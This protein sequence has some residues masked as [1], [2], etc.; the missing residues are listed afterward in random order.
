MRTSKETLLSVAA[1]EVMFFSDLKDLTKFC[2]SA[3]RECEKEQAWKLAYILSLTMIC[4]AFA[5]ALYP[6]ARVR[7]M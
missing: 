2:F 3:W 5:G 1:G 4:V 7:G 6:L